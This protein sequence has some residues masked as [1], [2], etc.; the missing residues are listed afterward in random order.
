MIPSSLRCRVSVCLLT[1]V[2]AA[3]A[4]LGGPQ[5]V[6]AA[7]ADSAGPSS[8]EAD[9]AQGRPDGPESAMRSA[10]A[11]S[12]VGE[13]SQPLPAIPAAGTVTRRAAFSRTESNGDGSYTSTF[14]TRPLHWKPPGTGEWHRSPSRT[15]RSRRG[16]L[17][18]R[19]RTRSPRRRC[20]SQA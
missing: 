11:V 6:T 14:A 3:I 4:S 9:S 5:G 19:V 18:L 1:L 12:G 15:D 20:S 17:G 2:T 10:G 8:A 7:P 16:Q 13:A